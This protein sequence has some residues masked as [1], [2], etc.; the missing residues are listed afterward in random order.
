MQMNRQ[1]H[2]DFTQH[3][4]NASLQGE[5]QQAISLLV[6]FFL[7]LRLLGSEALLVE[8]SSCSSFASLAWGQPL[9]PELS[10]LALDGPHSVLGFLR[11]LSSQ[12]QDL[13]TLLFC[14][15]SITR[16]PGIYGDLLIKT[17]RLCMDSRKTYK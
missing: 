11:L 13:F 15:H 1:M 8:G 6:P 12:Q 7:L 4:C 10:L 17:C 3:E 14:W 9:P 5:Q 2:S 16:V